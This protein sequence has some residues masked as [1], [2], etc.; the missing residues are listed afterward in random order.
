MQKLSW[1][2]REA[3][4]HCCQGV[5]EFASFPRGVGTKT[6]ETLLDKGLIVRATCQYYGTIGY[7]IT[8]AGI[9]ALD[10]RF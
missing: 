2:E 6:I 10:R 8:E 9:A 5:E 3:L 4:Q 7:E 1:R